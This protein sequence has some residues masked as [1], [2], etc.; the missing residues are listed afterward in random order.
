MRISQCR[1]EDTAEM[2]DGS[3]KPQADGGA[4]KNEDQE[5]ADLSAGVLRGM[6][7]FTRHAVGAQTAGAVEHHA[8]A[9]GGPAEATE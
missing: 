6:L 4:E 9:A 8:E 2:A 1:E 3:R 7:E 5:A